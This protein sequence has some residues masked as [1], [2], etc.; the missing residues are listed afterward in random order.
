MDQLHICPAG[1]LQRSVR[2]VTAQLSP[3]VSVHNRDE[4]TLV[5]ASISF[6]ALQLL[7]QLCSVLE[8]KM[9]A[10]TMTHHWLMF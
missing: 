1:R 9:A 5:F 2:G 6:L 8:R 7:L 3:A 10:D 4:S